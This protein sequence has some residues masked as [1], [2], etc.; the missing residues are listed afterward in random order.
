MFI[1]FSFYLIKFQIMLASFR[2]KKNYILSL[3]LQFGLIFICFSIRYDFNCGKSSN[4]LKTFYRYMYLNQ[5]GLDFC[6]FPFFISCLLLN[7]TLVPFLIFS[8]CL[9]LILHFPH[10]NL[11]LL[12]FYLIMFLVLFLVSHPKRKRKP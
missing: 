5:T 1:I 10:Y 12:T 7:F 4:L 11:S 2:L 9:P 3:S 8:S 6:L